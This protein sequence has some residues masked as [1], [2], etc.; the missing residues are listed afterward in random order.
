MGPTVILIVEDEAL[1]R[2]NVAYML[3]D[4]GYVV[5]EAANADEA[6]LLLEEETDISVVFTDINMPGTVDGLELVQTIKKRWPP[7]HLIVTSGKHFPRD[8]D[9]PLAAATSLSH[10]RTSKYYR[11]LRNSRSRP[12]F[13][14]AL[15]ILQ[16]P[17]AFRCNVGFGRC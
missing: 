6:I 13:G 11:W 7:M 2:L 8:G 10:I 16:S 14:D 12:P 1:I 15:R 17:Y 3:I 4:A 9:M 5:L